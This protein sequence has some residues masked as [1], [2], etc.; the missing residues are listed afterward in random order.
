MLENF[1]VAQMG[2]RLDLYG[3]MNLTVDYHLCLVTDIHDHSLAE[4]QVLSWLIMLIL[5]VWYL[6]NEEQSGG[7]SKNI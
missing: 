4:D 6:I 1:D 7:F 3:L 5:I 2:Q